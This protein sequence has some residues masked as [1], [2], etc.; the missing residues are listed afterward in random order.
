M[1]EI[2]T[3]NLEY[4]ITKEIITKLSKE[5]AAA[6][7]RKRTQ[8]QPQGKGKRK[9]IIP[10]SSDDNK[11]LGAMALDIIEDLNSFIFQDL[12]M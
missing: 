4:A 6:R 7:K 9:I 5:I 8:Q 2:E 1:E 3:G 10:D 12:L 11:E